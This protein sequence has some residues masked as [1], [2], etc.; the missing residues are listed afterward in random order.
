MDQWLE[1]F[2]FL[3]SSTISVFID[4]LEC[5]CSYVLSTP[6]SVLWDNRVTCLLV[7]VDVGLY[8]YYNILFLELSS[9]QSEN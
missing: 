6:F 8:F 2:M 5:N 1:V 4:W 9:K 3:F 7:K